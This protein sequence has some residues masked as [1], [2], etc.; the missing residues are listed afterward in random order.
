VLV[1]LLVNLIHISFEADE[2]NFRLCK[3]IAFCL[4]MAFEVTTLKQSIDPVIVQQL[5][6]ELVTHLSNGT[7]EQ[8]L[9]QWMRNLVGKLIE[10]CT[11]NT[12]TGLLTLIGDFE[13][14][15]QFTE[16]W[17]KLALKCFEQCGTR[18]CEI[19]PQ[20]KIQSALAALEKLL[21]RLTIEYIQ[22]STMGVRIITIFRAFLT[23]VIE[24]YPDSINPH[25]QAK[26]P[27]IL[28]LIA[29]PPE[30]KPVSLEPSSASLAESDSHRT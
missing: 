23:K 13:N 18:L 21:H 25:D 7:G 16:K 26:N 20:D 17:V 28:A 2:I 12:F 3:Y 29:I 14:R 11:L 1:L 22:E 10:E 24:K 6:Y 8:S 15:V 19:V 4:A 27:T 5:L 9:E 30:K